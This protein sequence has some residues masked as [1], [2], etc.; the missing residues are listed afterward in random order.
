MVKGAASKATFNI[1]YFFWG[2][3]VTYTT[4]KK[5]AE[6]THRFVQVGEGNKIIFNYIVIR[7]L[8]KNNSLFIKLNSYPC[9]L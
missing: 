6:F 3:G 1:K 9:L 7:H 2:G 4:W 5:D 8:T